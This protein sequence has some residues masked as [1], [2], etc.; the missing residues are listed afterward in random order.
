[1]PPFGCLPVYG[2]EAALPSEFPQ[3]KGEKKRRKRK[4]LGTD[5][6]KAL[7]TRVDGNDEEFQ[8]VT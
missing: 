5:L 6:L 2:V 7:S 8:C 3:I 4:Q 1:V